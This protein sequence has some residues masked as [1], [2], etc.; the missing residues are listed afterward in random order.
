MCLRIECI[1]RLALVG[2]VERRCTLE[3]FDLVDLLV[4]ITS[5]RE[6]QHLR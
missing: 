5:R 4:S 6:A 2:L 3:R 1:H